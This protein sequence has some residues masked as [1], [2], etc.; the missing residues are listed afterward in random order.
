MGLDEA[1]R[2]ARELVPIWSW[3]VRWFKPAQKS[4]KYYPNGF[5]ASTRLTA[6]RYIPPSPGYVMNLTAKAGNASIAF[7]YAELASSLTKTI[8]V[9]EAIAARTALASICI[10]VADCFGGRDLG[11]MNQPGY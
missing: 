1:S 8:T 2:W 5:T 4:A 7:R 9:D 10:S 6:C 3:N 11:E